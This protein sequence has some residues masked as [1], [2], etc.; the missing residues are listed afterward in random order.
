MNLQSKAG[1]LHMFLQIS[2]QHIS[3]PSQSASDSQPT[4]SSSPPGGHGY[5]GTEGQLLSPF[6]GDGILR[7][8]RSS[9]V[10]PDSHKV[11]LV[12]GWCVELS[13]STQY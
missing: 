8:K 6:A 2:G 3:S 12:C 7:R 13:D 1:F 9:L 5:T 4:K 11:W 10:S